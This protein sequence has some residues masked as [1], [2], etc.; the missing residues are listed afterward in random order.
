MKPLGDR[1]S[2]IRLEVVGLLWGTLE[3][4]TAARI[5]NISTTGALVASVV[6]AAVDSTQKMKLTIG[7][8]DIRVE[9]RVRHL[10]H[11]DTD[12]HGPQYRI[13]LEFLRVPTALQD[14]LG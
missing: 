2:R 10:Q 3:V 1:R 9:A 14:A 4:T 13:G 7:G 6:P 11:V 12:E 8:H 5:V